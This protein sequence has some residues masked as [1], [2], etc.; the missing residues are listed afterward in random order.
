MKVAEYGEVIVAA[1]LIESREGGLGI[2]LRRGRPSDEQLRG[3]LVER[4]RIDL[5]EM[6]QGGGKMIGAEFLQAQNNARKPV[7]G[8]ETEDLNGKIL[9][10]VEIAGR[11]SQNEGAFDQNRIVRIVAE[12]LSEIF[13]SEVEIANLTG[14]AARQ[15]AAGQ[16]R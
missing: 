2:F 10:L 6:I 5:L 3:Q 4:S 1:K 9:G 16:R 8:I 15:I 11:K 7:L 12:R 14:L 13:S